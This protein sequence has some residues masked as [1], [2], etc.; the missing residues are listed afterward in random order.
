MA[1]NFKE[2]KND[3]QNRRIREVIPVAN[4]S[5]KVFE[6]S[7]DDISVILEIQENLMKDV[8]DSGNDVE[9]EFSGLVVVKKLIPLLTDIEGIEDM[10]DEEINDV[11]SNPSVGLKRVS[12]EI[13][14][15]IM[16]ILSLVTAEARK[17]IIEADYNTNQFLLSQDTVNKTMKLVDKMNGNDELSQKI[18]GA[19]SKLEQLENVKDSEELQKLLSENKNSSERVKSISDY[20]NLNSQKDEENVEETQD[21]KT[22]EEDEKESDDL[23]EAPQEYMDALEEY[24]KAFSKGNG[25]S[26]F[27]GDE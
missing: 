14:S 18:K 11:A 15:I 1:V 19:Q 6:P 16:E 13:E 24:R 21:N 3:A 8:S 5:V 22:V 2:L 7:E 4:R 12:L 10:T 27:K 25:K 23:T 17:S 20:L 26:L 9:I